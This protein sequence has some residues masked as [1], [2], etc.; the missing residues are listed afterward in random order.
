MNKKASRMTLFL[1]VASLYCL[2]GQVPKT[3]EFVI[4]PAATTK[5]NVSLN[6]L[7]EHVGSTTK[8]LFES[9][10]S[11]VK[12]LGQAQ[13]GLARL[14][15]GV[16]DQ[17]THSVGCLKEILCASAAYNRVL[18]DIAD[19]LALLQQRC[20]SIIEKLI[21]NQAP[22]KKASKKNFQQ[23]LAVLTTAHQHLE[24]CLV[25]FQRVNNNLKKSGLAA[26]KVI[27]SIQA[28]TKELQAQD[29]IVQQVI[30]SI[31]TDHCLKNT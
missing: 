23:S 21:D 27:A 9:T 26:A 15:Q 16:A 29:S 1:L 3:S 20:S 31:N 13:C 5:K 17:D 2:Q 6:T 30:T 28:A 25:T 4:A 11:V 18:G 24:T 10:T 19:K 8:Q 12:H 7:K 22:F 14:Q